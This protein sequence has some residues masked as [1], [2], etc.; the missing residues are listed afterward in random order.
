MI[1]KFMHCPIYCWV[2][3]SLPVKYNDNSTN[4]LVIA[5]FFKCVERHPSPL[6][7]C[8]AHAS[9]FVFLPSSLCFHFM[10]TEE[11]IEVLFIQREVKTK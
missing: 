9:A 10:K 11:R 5:L 1:C 7:H 6:Y 8:N 3:H 4:C 2:L